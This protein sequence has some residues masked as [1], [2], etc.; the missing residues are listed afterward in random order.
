MAVYIYIA[1]PARF[2]LGYQHARGN[3]T[4]LKQ[5]AVRPTGTRKPER[6]AAKVMADLRPLQG[7]VSTDGC[8][9]VG[10]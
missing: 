5:E 10:P 2:C 1:M 8:I 7:L 9:A 3:C 6:E 4:V